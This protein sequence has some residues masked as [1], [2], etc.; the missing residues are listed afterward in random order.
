MRSVTVHKIGVDVRTD[1]A[2]VFLRDT[3]NGRILPIWIGMA[4]ATAIALKLQGQ[5]APRP[6][7]SDLLKTVLDTFGTR[8]LMV[9]IND[10]KDR[11]F[12]A[13]I[14]LSGTGGISTIEL[15]ARPSDALALALRFDA[16]IYV[17]D[18]IMDEAGVDEVLDDDEDNQ[19][20]DE[21]PAPH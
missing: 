9:V 5:Q 18:W 12:F 21:K 1:Q 4:E 20:E 11:I 10:M 7:T 17:S 8:V 13:R 15:D 3:E 14:F 19:A 16:P 2:V 6:L